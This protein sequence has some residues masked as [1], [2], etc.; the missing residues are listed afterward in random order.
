MKHYEHKKYI[1]GKW[2]QWQS[3][4]Y[5]CATFW[6]LITF[7]KFLSHCKP[8]YVLKEQLNNGVC[9]LFLPYTIKSWKICWEHKGHDTS[10]DHQSSWCCL[11]QQEKEGKN[12][13]SICHFHSI[14]PVSCYFSSEG[15]LRQMK[16]IC[17]A[18]LSTTLS[19]TCLFTS[20]SLCNFF[21]VVV[22]SSSEHSFLGELLRTEQIFLELS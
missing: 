3:G 10:W 2:Y 7:I 6:I 16:L 20:W 22:P 21:V 12:R 4:K 18:I 15:F 5:I 8:K 1:T 19:S 9:A 13:T 14:F 17:V 11:Q